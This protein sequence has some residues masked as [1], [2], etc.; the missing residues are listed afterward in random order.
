VAGECDV[1]IIIDRL[2]DGDGE[3]FESFRADFNCG[4]DMCTRWVYSL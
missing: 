1:L 3:Q 2:S 4:H